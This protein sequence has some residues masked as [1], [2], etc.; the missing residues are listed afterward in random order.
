SPERLLKTIPKAFLWG[1]IAGG[2]SLPFSYSYWEARFIRSVE[3]ATQQILRKQQEVQ[4]AINQSEQ[5]CE[6]LYERIQKFYRPLLGLPSLPP[7]EWHGGMGGAA[8]SPAEL[9]LYRG[10]RIVSEYVF[11][12]KRFAELNSRLDRVPCI[13]P[14][15]GPIVSGFGPRINPITG[16]PQIHTGLDI[17]APHGTPV[18]AAAAGKVIVSGWDH[19]GYGIQ[20]EIDHL[21]GLVTKY[22]HL[23]RTA[24]QVGDVVVRGQVIGYVGSTGLSTGDHL[25]YEV[26]ERGVKVDPRKY[27]LLP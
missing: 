25:H 5:R 1:T 26:I 7:S 13:M 6:Y 23:S 17:D 14:V 18:R 22:A 20:V 16:L 9:S 19:G 15:Q 21:N 12:S 27:I 8:S 3:E 11:L 2:V 10:S 4:A 24:V